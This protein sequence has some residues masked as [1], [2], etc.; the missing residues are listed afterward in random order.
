MI[1]SLQR[2]LQH[3]FIKVSGANGMVT[4]VKA[5]IAMGSAKVVATVTGASGIAMLGQLQ[6]FITISTLLS[7]GGFSQG[8]TKYISEHRKDDDIIRQFISSAVGITTVLTSV[9]AVVLLSFPAFFTEYIFHDAAFKPLVI[10]LAGMLLFFNLNSLIVAVVNGFQMY[11]QYFSINIITTFAAFILTVGLVLQYKVFGALLAIILSQSV[12]FA[13]SLTIVRKEQWLKR[14][15]FDGID[16]GKVRLLF[17]YTLVTVCSSILW[18]IVKIIIRNQVIANISAEE[19]GLWQAVVNINDY[20]ATF[21]IGSFSVYLLP[22]LASISDKVLLKKELLFV[23]KVIVPASL[24]IFT[25]IYFLREYIILLLY[26][27]QFVKCGDYLLLQMVGSFFWM[28][29]VP[30]M[31]FMLA[32][33]LTTA[34]MVNEIL[35]ALIYIVLALILI[36]IYQV[37]GI[38]IAFALYNFFYLLTN[39]AFNWKRFSS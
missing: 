22:K 33:G 16:R 37:Q 23:Y 2:I 9:I 28:C 11:R 4:I 38:Q 25:V 18:P 15:S 24:I 20:I 14:I 29:K 21:T 3:G 5:A 31:N 7:S 19:A 26:S 27:E 39:V 1:K 32:K 36:P 12:V 35:Y 6:N 30:I 17:K 13:F 34:F 10:V 8:L